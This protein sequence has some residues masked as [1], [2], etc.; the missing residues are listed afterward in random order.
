MTPRERHQVHPHCR[1]RRLFRTLRP[2]RSPFPG[3]SSGGC[4][5]IHLVQPVD[6]GCPC[7]PTPSS[8]VAWRGGRMR[9]QWRYSRIFC[10]DPCSQFPG[11]AIATVQG[12]KKHSRGFV[13]TSGT[14]STCASRNADVLVTVAGFALPR[15]Q[16][17]IRLLLHYSSAP[18][19]RE[20]GSS[21]LRGD[22]CRPHKFA[23][24]RT[25]PGVQTHPYRRY[26]AYRISGGAVLEAR[27]ECASRPRRPSPVPLLGSVFQR[28][29]PLR[30]EQLS[31]DAVREKV[32]TR[33]RWTLHMP[34]NDFRSICVRDGLNPSIA[35]LFFDVCKCSPGRITCPSSQLSI[36]KTCTFGV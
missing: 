23:E 6:R 28:A 27:R 12:D 15:W 3:Q 8:H 29:D 31:G 25:R 35:G 7:L 33:R 22:G 14:A 13:S 2:P 5:P 26:T 16:P 4:T 9:Q 10:N 34:K 17:D 18:F 21:T 30:G 20:T 19:S 11:G 1:T 32:F 36:S 24:A